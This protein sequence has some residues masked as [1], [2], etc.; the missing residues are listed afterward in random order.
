MR[1]ID[2]LLLMIEVPTTDLAD[3]V[4]RG[5]R[6]L[7]RRHRWQA[8]TVAASVAVISAAGVVVHG[9][10]GTPGS[11]PSYAGQS[12]AATPKPR[13]THTT[14]ACAAS[15]RTLQQQVTKKPLTVDERMRQLEQMD[16]DPGTL[17]TLRDWRDVLAAHLDPGGDRLRMAQNIGGGIGHLSTKLDWDNGGMLEVGVATSWRYSDWNTDPPG[18]GEKV[19]F[20]GH[21][22]RVL[23]DGGDLW[24]AVEHDDGEVVMLYAS[25]SFGNNGTS[26]AATGLTA[27][28]LLD[29]AADPRLALPNPL[30][31]GISG[32]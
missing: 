15:C 10:T 12:H 9:A 2:Q 1:D 5:E 21:D 29:A 14:H 8:G 3:D 4:R 7:R 23:V 6:A 17:A 28:Q 20:R 26:I 25:A 30:P 16:T 19:T 24:V 18:P 32:R 11:A 27:P 22:A 31:S 13:P